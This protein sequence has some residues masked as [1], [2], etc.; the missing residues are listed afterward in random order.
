MVATIVPFGSEAFLVSLILIDKYNIFILLFAASLGNI[1]GSVLNW[2]CGYYSIYFIRKKWFPISKKKMDKASF[3]FK[4]YGKWSLLFSWVPFMGDP[5][6]FVA[7]SFKYSF[8]PFL[9][10]VSIGKT[11]RYIVVYLL[12]IWSTSIF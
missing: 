12:T 8:L 7:G 9:I 4:K 5:I 3:Y 11:G 1:L 2:I 10:L 6:T